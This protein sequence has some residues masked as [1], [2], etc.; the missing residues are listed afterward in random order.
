M[1]DSDRPS[2]QGQERLGANE[3][4]RAFE[5]LFDSTYRQVLA[6]C[7]RRTPSREDAEDVVAA[8]YLVAWTKIEEVAAARVPLAWLY[9]VAYRSLANQRRGSA[10]WARLLERAKRQQT[11]RRADDPALVVEGSAEVERL[12]QA[13]ESLS[14]IDQE[15]LR[16]AAWEG[17]SN[18]EIAQVLRTSE[19]AVRSRLHRAR[20]RLGEA[21]QRLGGE[22][23]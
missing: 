12:R 16:L 9:G 19:G 7:L 14:R 2:D 5:E 23:A 4:L 21:Y 8:T 20:R 1:T 22:T 10:R 6:Y 3:A 15:L 11:F 17:L 13:L 18:A